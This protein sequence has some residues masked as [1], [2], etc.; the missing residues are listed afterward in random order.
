MERFNI[1]K[2]LAKIQ[3]K[4]KKIKFHWDL[5]KSVYALVIGLSLV[6]GLNTSYSINEYDQEHTIKINIENGYQSVYVKKVVGS[7]FTDVIDS[8]YKTAYI[9]C[10]GGN[11]GYNIEDR[12][13]YITKI[14][15]DIT[16]DLVFNVDEAKSQIDL[17]SLETIP[18]NDGISYY[19]KSTADNNYV[20]V[21]YLTFRIVRINGD[22][23]YRLV[24]DSVL[25]DINYGD[26]DYL[27]SNLYN[28]L[29]NWFNANLSGVDYIVEKDFDNQEYSSYG[30]DFNNSLVNFNGYWYGKVGTLSVNEIMSINKGNKITKE[31]YLYGTYLTMNENDTGGVWAVKNEGIIGSVSKNETVGVRPVINV[32]VKNMSGSGSADDPYIINEE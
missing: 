25:D 9:T 32:L 23:T 14:D 16:C 30:E 31:S 28:S 11:F 27:N 13:A 4:E 12:I 24:L 6:I 7:T 3:G 21:N 20:R 5:R 17:N 22:G 26:T 8:N 15:K 18:D 1:E 10:D 19:F 29:N 2:E